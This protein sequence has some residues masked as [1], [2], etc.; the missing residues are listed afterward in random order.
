M[1][2][3]KVFKELFTTH[4]EEYFCMSVHEQSISIRKLC[5]DRRKPEQR[6]TFA[7]L[8]GEF[9]HKKIKKKTL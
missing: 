4:Y 8:S 7:I 3:L 2:K 6:V 5:T 9:E 1:T